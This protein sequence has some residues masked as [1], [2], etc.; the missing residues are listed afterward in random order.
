MN[1]RQMEVFWAV[2]DS[3][4]FTRGAQSACLSQSTVSQH[5][6]D[7]EAEFGVRLLDRTG[8]KVLP[9]S[10]GKLL[11]QRIRRIVHSVRETEMTM[12]RFASVEEAPLTVS[13]SNVP[14]N[15]L[16]PPLLPTLNMR[17][18]GIAIT[19]LCTDSRQAIELLA[20]EEAEIA[21]VGTRFT[22]DRY[23]W[24]S[25]VEDR[26]VLIVPQAHRWVRADD[27]E[28]VDFVTE[29]LILRESG[30]GTGRAVEQALRESGLSLKQLRIRAR[31]GSNEAVKQAVIAG[32]GVAF[33]SEFSVGQELSCGALVKK[34]MPE[35]TVNRSFHI[36]RLADRE[37]S[38]AAAAFAKVLEQ[39]FLA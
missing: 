13:C 28:L 26:I 5:I 20:R 15:Y 38:P 32:A 39:R 3:G 36:A 31:L 8:K 16:V 21:V 11:L 10:A 23:E 22:D 33:V 37:L 35:V 27:V 7:L 25:L 34:L 2:V 1:L 14:G 30:S 12:R 17:F 29:P 9:T 18:P 6:A 4:S 19:V 24:S